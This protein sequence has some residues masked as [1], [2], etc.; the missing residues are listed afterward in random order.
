MK[1]VLLF[2]LCMAWAAQGVAQ[3]TCAA[4][5]DI[6][7]NLDNNGVCDPLVVQ[8]N[9]AATPWEVATGVFYV[10]GC[11]GTGDILNLM[12]FS[13][14]A[15]GVS[16]D[17][18]VSNGPG[19]Y[20][21]SIV[22]LGP[23][24]CFDTPVA[25]PNNWCGANTPISLD[26]EL[27]VGNTYYVV[28]GF[29]GNVTGTFDLCVF[30][31]EPADNDE[32]IDA[33][34]LPDIDG[35]C[36]VV[37]MNYYYY[38]SSEFPDGPCL[39]AASQSV[40]FQFTAQGV[41]IADLHID[42]APDVANV[43]VWDFFGQAPCDLGNG[44]IWA[45]ACKTDVDANNPIVMDNLLEPG[46]V[47]YIEVTFDNNAV[48]PFSVCL[49]APEQAF[50]DECDDAADYPIPELSIENNCLTSIAGNALSNDWPSTDLILPPCGDAADSYNVWFKFVAQGPD[51]E[52]EVDGG[53][54]TEM[55]ALIQFNG[56]NVCDAGNSRWLDCSLGAELDI[57][58]DLEIG[59]EY[60]VMVGFDNN[61]IADYCIDIFNPMPP[62]NDTACSAIPL[63]S[64]S[65]G[66]SVTCVNDCFT[67][68]YANPDD[69][70]NPGSVIPD[71]VPY[72]ENTVWF[73]M[74]LVDPNNVGFEITV[75]E[76]TARNLGLVIG[77]F[78]DC[79]G[80]FDPEAFF[81][82]A[83]SDPIEFGPVDETL[84]YYLLVGTQEIDEG[85]FTI[86]V[87][88]IPPCFD[89]N[90]CDD[91]MGVSSAEDLGVLVTVSP[92]GTGGCAGVGDPFTC[93]G[94]CNVFADEIE[95]NVNCL[96]TNDPVVW[97]TFGTDGNAS[98]ANITVTSG[99]F[100][101]PAFQLFLSLDGTCGS[102]VPWATGNDC[103][104]GSGGE[105]SITSVDVGGGEVYF[106]AVGGVNTVGGDFELCISILENL[107]ACTL[108]ADV[109]V[110]GRSNNGPLEG[111]FFPGEV[112]SICM[113]VNTYTPVGNGCQW[114]Q[115][116]IP[117]FG[118]G[119]DPNSF[120]GNG[121]PL[122]A[123][124]GGSG[125]PAA[126]PIGTA[127]QWDWLGDVTY[128]H[129]NCFY[130]VGD[131]DGNGTLDMC[132]SLYDDDCSGPGLTGGS[133]GPCW[134][135]TPGNQLPYGWYAYGIDGNCTSMIG[136]PTVDYGDGN[137]C[138][139]TMG[140]WN[141]CF[142]LTVRSFPDCQ[143][144]E[145]TVDL[146]VGFITV[147]DG[148]VGS[149]TGGASI[150]ANDEPIDIR[151]PGCC[152]DLVDLPGVHDPIC[153]D[154]LFN[155]VI[156][157][158]N[159]QADFWTWTAD[160]GSVTGARDGDGATGTLILDNLVNPGSSAEVVTYTILGFDGGECPAVIW[161]VT[162][163][164]LPEILVELEPFRACAT[165]TNPYMLVPD[166]SGGDGF[167]TYE[168]QD[169]SSSS[170][171]TL[172]M[173]VAGQIYSVTVTDGAD[174]TAE[175]SVT[176][177]VYDGVD[178]E[179]DAPDLSRCI[180]DGSIDIDASADGGIPA[181]S[182]EWTTPMGNIVA[183]SSVPADE[184]GQWVISVTDMDGC[185]GENSVMLEFFESP[186]LEIDRPSICLNNPRFE[187][188]TAT[189]TNGQ[190]P[191]EVEWDTPIGN[192]NG[193]SILIDEIGDY[194]IT[195]TDANGCSAEDAFYVEE[196]QAPV[197]DLRVKNACPE[198]S[199]GG[200]DV[201]VQPDGSFVDFAWSNGS[202]PVFGSGASIHVT[203]PDM[204]TVTVTNTDG[205]ISTESVVY[206][207]WP[208]IPDI[209]VDT[210]QICTGG[211]ADI[212]GDDEYT[213]EWYTAG[214]TSSGSIITV[215][216]EQE[217]FVE[218]FDRNGCSH[219]EN[220]VVVESPDLFANINADTVICSGS[221]VEITVDPYSTVRW[222]SDPELT[223]VIGFRDNYTA[224]DPGWYY[225][226]VW[227]GNGCSGID[228]ILIVESIPDPTID[229]VPA[230]CDGESSTLNV[231]GTWKSILWSTG[232]S[233]TTIT[234]DTADIFYVTVTDEFDCSAVSMPFIVTESDLPVPVISGAQRFC[235]GDSTTLDAG[236]TFETYSWSTG[237]SGQIISV[238]STDS[239]FV[240]VTNIAGCAGVDTFVVEEL[241]P[242]TPQISGDQ[243][244]CNLEA[245][246]LDA[247]G[248]FV[249]Y[250]W[251]SSQT[252]AAIQ[253]DAAGTYAVTV[254]DVDGCKGTD[255]IIVQAG[256]P[257][258]VISGDIE[259]CQGETVTL[260]A[261]PGYTAYTW[262]TTES[263]PTIDVNTTGTYKVVV[264]DQLGCTDSTVFDFAINP[265]PAPNINGSTTFCVG[266]FTVLD[267]GAGYV[268][269][270]WSDSQTGQTINVTAQGPIT[271]TVTDA[272][273]CSETASV[274][275]TES[276]ELV[277]NVPDTAICDGDVIT[278]IVGNFATYNWFDNS[279]SPT[280]Q[281]N[282]GGNYAV[283][284]SDASGCTGTANI[285]VT[286]YQKPVATVTNAAEACNTSVGGVIS[287]IDFS[288]LITGGDASGSWNDVD[289]SGASGGYPDL[290]FTGVIP[291][292]Y[293][294]EYTTN[295]AQ[296]PCDEETYPVIVTV[297]DCV[298]PSP[299]IDAAPDMC[300]DN[301]TLNLETL[302]NDS[303]L[304]GGVWTIV[305][306]PSGSSP[307]TISGSVFNSTNADP[308][309]YD[310][311]YTISGIPANCTDSDVQ[312]ITVH[313]PSDAGL[314]GQPAQVCADE[315]TVVTLANLITGAHSG[316]MWIETSTTTSQ[317]G[318][319]D[320]SG[321][322]DTEL[323][324]PG[325]YT[326][327]YIIQGTAPCPND[328]TTIEVV[329][330]EVPI[331]DA[332]TDRE[333]TCEKPNA[334]LDGSGSSQ[335]SNFKYNWRLNGVI[336][337]S[338]SM[339]T[340]VNDAGIYEL[341]V[342]NTVTG[343][344]SYDEVEVKINGNIPVMITDLFLPV[345]VGDAPASVSVSSLSGGTSPFS[346]TLN[347]AEATTDGNYSDLGPGDYTLLVND[348]NGCS[349]KFDFT[350]N[351]T[352]SVDG[353]IAGEFI[354]DR[355]DNFTLTYDLIEGIADSVVW[356]DGDGNLLCLQ[357]DSI[358]I[359][360]VN[361]MDVYLTIYNKDGCFVTLSA[362]LFVKIVKEVFVPNVFTPNGDGVNDLVTVY[363]PEGTIVSKFEIFSRWGELV[364]SSAEGIPANAPELGW[365][366]TF[367][368][369][370]MQ[371][372]VFVYH[373]QVLYPGDD[374]EEIVKG[375]IT[376][377]R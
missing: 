9:T 267:A 280:Y 372:G 159:V 108:N 366:G 76:V 199:V 355:G 216:D 259:A 306:T 376:L 90:F 297:W 183:G 241:N 320:I 100:D 203:V 227:D 254:T 111:P 305:S 373:A 138:S 325:T 198:D 75:A 106:L 137:T 93:I 160:A 371:P 12:Y 304:V 151:L 374:V 133:A 179:I 315:D 3:F 41:S 101:A 89:N 207:V 324:L 139:S 34:P 200:E 140:P 23:A 155:W 362:S 180:V 314:A 283:T 1:R 238:N 205:C 186:E 27:I 148:E 276:T 71:C 285:V 258:P 361:N 301:G 110:E 10:H 358:M 104:T 208:E 132:N 72:I 173:L 185:T 95:V 119:W 247:T 177:D 42:G 340:S 74:Q 126:S 21:V 331:A 313:E 253:T 37:P 316:G 268:S 28:V 78:N 210:V 213:Y 47:Y 277:L 121:M 135:G 158:V 169:G 128:H 122:G 176:L 311:R 168:W 189:I 329:I 56:G 322:F 284:V 26:N 343:C 286:E 11:S 109:T 117:T 52:I 112:V 25:A 124:L 184:S 103:T 31:P 149:W 113:N 234:T 229:G 338:G 94:G 33:W 45:G 32:C 7:G 348:A 166:V 332:G 181:Y 365:D 352:T 188:L 81:C 70:P 44:V 164:V 220:I 83:G 46:E 50:N 154:G 303:T 251:S 105:A 62:D 2:V 215:F 307:A 318:F 293:L 345:C 296:G 335:G 178:V 310:I 195:V 269:Y 143:T 212:E 282:T 58:D 13:F 273:G 29:D 65:C 302:F 202:G 92:D 123:M 134:Q 262:S 193:A 201:V 59:R 368:G 4:P 43:T 22:E 191:Y 35:N 219:E 115:G 337:S 206:D 330:E 131:F 328:A 130:N 63:T 292:D 30:N 353:S 289:G 153:S 79:T 350:V 250:A 67:T 196:R 99:D 161:E 77:T 187:Q 204:Y 240:T 217:I 19:N 145:T 80:A 225:V 84:T 39:A 163:E 228:S 97:Y 24:G 125:F 116:V 266:G 96:G 233:T 256:N 88:E 14:V 246:T 61:A 69:S 294:F 20:L 15:Q 171:L 244:V 211:F 157:P 279:D 192:R 278:L 224:N 326:F 363:A 349:D 150:C 308:G 6:S 377:I 356:T 287:T 114:L 252:G 60:Y 165:P 347:G 342:V 54:A 242:V 236:G 281:V 16:A 364:Y 270:D 264:I 336:V 8:D 57:D 146:S 341:E 243:I 232:E 222:Y 346:Y 107:T 170:S 263:T 152:V 142:D 291:G 261:D 102:M 167:Y 221:A 51:V 182:F 53:A 334:D 136:H 375:D 235:F 209:F 299:G 312:Q 17:I 36:N 197:I 144:D 172:D 38:P 309:T 141:F 369:D 245:V 351:P 370:D 86:C 274:T 214:G 321:K 147:A 218:V 333:I 288:T 190:G 298:C 354:V 271:V 162:V 357:C 48:G 120:D 82:G 275:I 66:S 339:N 18:E 230:I 295:S 344:K 327:E 226:Q 49:D 290:D 248:P 255:D 98:V 239:V 127:A 360:A 87:D 64:N 359:E 223:I 323:E 55:I 319:D 249:T 129:D 85:T 237:E 367:A 68:E 300:A 175:A 174:C 91:P 156:D 5:L 40:W 257:E 260:S 317:T 73:T 272:K 118:N 194:S 265:N 231:V